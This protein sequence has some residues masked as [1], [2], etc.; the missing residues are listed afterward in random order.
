MD[1]QRPKRHWLM[2]TLLTLAVLC[3][4][5]VGSCAFVTRDREVRWEEEV[6][7]NTGEMIVVKRSM[8]WTFQGGAGN[9]F[10]MAMRGNPDKQ[11]I[12]FSY[13]GRYY[14]YSGGA[15]ILWITVAPD[16]LPNLVAPAGSLAWADRNYYYCVDPF[17]VQF[18]PNPDG[19]TW[20]WP[21]QIEPWLYGQPYNVMAV[22]NDLLSQRK[23]RFTVADRIARDDAVTRDSQ[24][25][26]YVLIDAA[27]K[28]TDCPK[29]SK[30]WNFPKPTGNQK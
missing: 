10:D 20:T 28:T 1:T 11:V 24:L 26:H 30:T 3:I 16:G 8:P 5:L 12:E 21:T 17:Y 22:T 25:N 19:K 15:Y 13:K 14:S 9:P 27:R 4:L 23:T 7:L 18:K 6:P 29:D 2:T